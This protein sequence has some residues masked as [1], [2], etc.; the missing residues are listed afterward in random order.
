MKPKNRFKRWGSLALALIF[1]GTSLSGLL[2][3]AAPHHSS[4]DSA[5]SIV[6]N[7]TSIQCVPTISN[8]PSGSGGNNSK[9][10][11]DALSVSGADSTFLSSLGT[12]YTSSD[13]PDEVQAYKDLNAQTGLLEITFSSSIG[14]ASPNNLCAHSMVLYR[15]LNN[16]TDPDTFYGLW[17]CADLATGQP[18]N[19]NCQ[20][21]NRNS[22]VL[23]RASVIPGG[24][25]PTLTLHWPG[26]SDSST[27]IDTTIPLSDPNHVLTSSAFGG[28][29]TGGGG[30]GSTL[31]SN[32]LSGASSGSGYQ[33]CLDAQKPAYFLDAAHLYFAG[34]T[35]EATSQWGGDN[36]YYTLVSSGSN[37]ALQNLAPQFQVGILHNKIDL[38]I[39]D[40]SK[41]TDITDLSNTLQGKFGSETVT[42]SFQGGSGNVKILPSGTSPSGTIQIIADYYPDGTD[43]S[44]DVIQIVFAHG[45]GT[46]EDHFYG[47]YAFSSSTT[48]TLSGSGKGYNCGSRAPRFVLNGAPIASDEAAKQVVPATWYLQVNDGFCTE[49]GIPVKI[50]LLPPGTAPP[51]DTGTTQPTGT[52]VDCGGGVLNWIFCTVIELGLKAGN[53]LDSWI[54]SLLN[55]DVQGTFDTSTKSGKGYYTAWNSFRIIATGLLIIVGLVMVITQAL[56]VEVFDAYTTR[57]VLPRLLIAAVAISLS[58]PLMKFIITFFDTLGFD[59]RALIYAPFSH[60]GSGFNFTDSLIADGAVGIALWTLGFASL[61]LILSAVVA[62]MVGVVILVFRQVAIILLVVLA[63]IGIVFSILPGTQRLWQMWWENFIGLMLVFPMISAVIAICHVF[64]AVARS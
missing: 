16:V 35:Y 43:A 59:V 32:C 31:L 6:A 7:H 28:G 54:T 13:S 20:V 42:Y 30:T 47:T 49:I 44:S 37:G 1:L 58:W 25:S 3:V 5:A 2:N 29:G 33:A 38:N 34:D 64:S 24:A 14:G 21:G 36:I 12:V 17:H 62:L 18:L 4:A 26:P 48:F 40:S 9:A 57:R 56:G 10:F 52:E 60:A 8:T 53:T 23:V 11:S 27:W 51:G 55:I 45:A 46:N 19:S 41:S 15:S 61:L 39:D 63:P 50:Q 22:F